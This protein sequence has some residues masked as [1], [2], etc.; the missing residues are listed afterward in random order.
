MEAHLSP[1]WWK[2]PRYDLQIFVLTSALRVLCTAAF[3]CFLFAIKSVQCTGRCVLHIWL[4]VI[5]RFLSSSN[6][7]MCFPQIWRYM[8]VLH[9]CKPHC[10]SGPKPCHC[11]LVCSWRLW[12]PRLLAGNMGSAEPLS[13]ALKCWSPFSDAICSFA[14]Q[15]FS[16]KWFICF[17]QSSFS[18]G[19]TVTVVSYFLVPPFSCNT[20]LFVFLPTCKFH[21]AG[22]FINQFSSFS[23][24]F[25]LLGSLH[26]PHVHLSE[27]CLSWPLWSA[28][29]EVVRSVYAVISVDFIS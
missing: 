18:L 17:L 7:A 25:G 6:K 20:W 15:L 16:L 24:F 14:P 26:F 28:R 11:N 29:L 8:W 27:C 10:S 9:L 13:F 19:D 3:V 23:H 22:K 21:F 1:R 2:E 5:V 12:L 4:V